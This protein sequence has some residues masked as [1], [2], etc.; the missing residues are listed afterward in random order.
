MLRTVHRM[1]MSKGFSLSFAVIP[2]HKCSHNPNVPPEMRRKEDRHSVG[3]NLELTTL[4]RQKAQDRS[5][6][7]MQHGFSHNEDSNEYWKSEFRGLQMP[8]VRLR[9]EGGRKLLTEVFEEP[10]VTFVAPQEYLTDSMLRTLRS[11]GFRCYCGGI[12][13][14]PWSHAVSLLA[15]GQ[16]WTNPVQRIR[17]GGLRTIPAHIMP[18]FRLYSEYVEEYRRKGLDIV[19]VVKKRITETVARNSYFVLLIHNWD[20]FEDWGSP[21]PAMKDAYEAVLEFVDSL[22]EDIWKCR[23]SDIADEKS[24]E[25]GRGPY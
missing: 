6:E 8:D 15:L 21:R 17:E 1:A 4:L 24:G 22:G 12:V 3:E 25:P 14:A 16:S 10:I 11:Q 18:S 19:D 20:F 9:I 7:V 2:M 23:V 13:S 5:V